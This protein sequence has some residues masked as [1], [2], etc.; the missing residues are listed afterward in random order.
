[1]A[2]MRKTKVL[3]K[4]KKKK[5]FN[6]ILLV[7]SIW[8]LLQFFLPSFDNLSIYERMPNL[9][10]GKAGLVI[11]GE[12]ITDSYPIIYDDAEY[13]LP[14]NVINKYVDKT[15]IRNDNYV[16]CAN[17]S[18][19][20]RYEIDNYKYVLNDKIKKGKTRPEE[21]ENEFY[22]PMSIL[23]DLYDLD[24]TYYESSNIL[25]MNTTKYNQD[26]CIVL[27]AMSMRET[28][29]I[30]SSIVGNVYEGEKI[31]RYT[32]DGNWSKIINSAGIV[33][34]IKSG[35]LE[36]V[37]TIYHEKK[38]DKNIE[39][40]SGT[41][42]GEITVT[43]ENKDDGLELNFN[44]EEKVKKINVLWYQVNSKT[45][46]PKVDDLEKIPGMTHMC[47]TWFEIVDKDGNVKDKTDTSII[48]WGHQN[49]YK[50]W[51]L[52][53][54]PFSNSDLSH[55]FLSNAVSRE[56]TIKQLMAFCNKYNIDGINVD[57]ESIKEKTGVYYVQFIRELSIFAK[58]NKLE[59]SL[60]M[61][62]PSQSTQHYKRQEVQAFVDY[63]C[64]MAY[65]EHWSTCK[66]AGSIGSIPW[67]E[68]GIVETLEE[69]P[70]EKLVLGIPLYTRR[71]ETDSNNNVI[72]QKA[73]GME[74]AIKDLKEH[75]AE[76]VFDDETKQNYGEYKDKKSTFKIWLEDETSIKQRLDLAKKYDLCGVAS[77]KKGFENPEIWGLYEN[78]MK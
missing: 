53:T 3:N 74:N 9:L 27:N 42:Y 21:H 40:N 49:G 29:S 65:D 66:E 4:K 18:T 11:D 23:K 14:L 25:E 71:W 24:F 6:T 60:D 22:I 39:L 37:D 76:I 67:V 17:K 20:I 51:A 2:K 13:L 10:S 38:D 78:Y 28:T 73:L 34:Y 32:D 45:A 70:K 56:N 8:I 16:I 72:S 57:I 7:F 55:E 50:V 35:Y 31:K 19:Y 59:L 64:L 44:K 47:F 58:K 52:V 62:M 12:I 63:F 36:Y 69:V 15:I 61:Y 33:G 77:W 1:M 68:K 26:E 48:K 75:K 46:N 41:T 54:N 5:I 43:L 30:K